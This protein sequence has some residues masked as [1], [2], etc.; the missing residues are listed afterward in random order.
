MKGWDKRQKRPQLFSETIKKKFFL[1]PF[2]FYYHVNEQL[3]NDHP[4]FGENLRQTHLQL[5]TDNRTQTCSLFVFISKSLRIF[6]SSPF[7]I[8]FSVKKKLTWKEFQHGFQKK[9]KKWRT[10]VYFAAEIQALRIQ[11]WGYKV[12]Y[13]NWHY[14][15][16]RWEVAG[17]THAPPKTGHIPDLKTNK[18]QNMSRNIY[19]HF[20]IFFIS[21][22]LCA[23]N[24]GTQSTPKSYK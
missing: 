19:H 10:L 18:Q 2:P 3:T 8:L 21:V 4:P 11:W 13:R 9:K 14:G 17:P 5:N 6:I 12:Q 1:N 15:S 23:E 22:F 7:H 20:F 16:E 24:L